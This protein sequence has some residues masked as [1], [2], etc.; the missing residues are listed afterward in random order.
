MRGSSNHQLLLLQEIERLIY[1]KIMIQIKI[2]WCWHA[3]LR[4]FNNIWKSVLRKIFQFLTFSELWNSIAQSNSGNLGNL[5]ND[6]SCRTWV[7]YAI[8]Y[9][10]ISQI[11]MTLQKRNT[12]NIEKLFRS[13]NNKCASSVNTE[14]IPS[15]VEEV[16]FD[17][18]K[19]QMSL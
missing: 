12:E 3:D 16:R 7:V 14:V 11:I 9:K 4:F 5:C 19:L 2:I 6:D 10:K 8:T 17:E 18:W 13:G 1:L 15:T